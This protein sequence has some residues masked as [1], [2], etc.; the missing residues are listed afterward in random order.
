M[1]RSIYYVYTHEHPVDGTVVYV[2]MGQKGRAWAIANSGGDNAAYGNRSKDHFNWFLQLE[3]NNYTLD[4]IVNIKARG[5]T[6]KEALSVE[7]GLIDEYRPTFNKV[8]GIKLLKMTEEKYS[9]AVALREDG[10]SYSKIAEELGFSP[11]TVHRAL[12]G[13][14]KNIGEEYGH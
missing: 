8:M 9:K 10:M 12:N 3:A 14:T 5:L 7:R 1:N 4:Q 2:G 6:K 13:Q 11:M